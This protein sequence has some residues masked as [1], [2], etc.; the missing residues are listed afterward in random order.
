MDVSVECACRH[1]TRNLSYPFNKVTD[2]V[3]YIS[4]F[5]FLELCIIKEERGKSAREN[6]LESSM[7]SR[8]RRPQ[9]LT[10]DFN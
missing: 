2:Y 5:P 8:S 10:A 3:I 9:Q 1:A 7:G 4:A 6:P